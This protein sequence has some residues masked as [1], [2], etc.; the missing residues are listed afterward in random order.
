MVLEYD[1]AA[2][3][4]K[5]MVGTEQGGVLMCNRKAKNPGDRVGANYT[6]HHGPLTGLQRCGRGSGGPGGGAKLGRARGGPSSSARLRLAHAN[7]V[8]PCIT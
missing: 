2:G 5:F 7:P 8:L 6:G 3:P 1:P 4:T